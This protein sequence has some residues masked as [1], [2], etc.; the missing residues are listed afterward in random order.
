MALPVATICY[1]W[2][3]AA[4][5]ADRRQP[6][7]KQSEPAANH[8]TTAPNAL[9]HFSRSPSRGSAF[10]ARG[11]TSLNLNSRA[12][13]PGDTA[14]LLLLG[15][16]SHNG[17]A[18]EEKSFFFFFFLE[19]NEHLL[20]GSQAYRPILRAESLA[21]SWR[22]LRRR[23]GP[24]PTAGS[25]SEA[26]ELKIAQLVVARCE[27]AT[28]CR[29][30]HFKFRLFFSPTLSESRRRELFSTPRRQASRALQVERRDTRAAAVEVT[31]RLCNGNGTTSWTANCQSGGAALCVSISWLISLACCSRLSP[32]GLRQKEWQEK[33]SFRCGGVSCPKWAAC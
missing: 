9:Q 19:V 29:E 6:L 23:S 5:A 21:T 18:V 28:C 4:A 26:S 22:Y 16:L 13:Q 25:T 11:Q 2:R 7:A 3:A 10:P 20:R 8:A 12:R 1:S 32:S 33:K 14:A 31:V 24:S 30:Q 17:V 15:C 27:A